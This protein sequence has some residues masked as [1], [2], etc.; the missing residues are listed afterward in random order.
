MTLIQ[1]AL[2]LDSILECKLVQIYGLI[3][4]CQSFIHAFTVE[5]E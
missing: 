4:Q 5:V 3:Q 2:E 1:A